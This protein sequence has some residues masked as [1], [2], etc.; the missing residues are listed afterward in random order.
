M[1]RHVLAACVLGAA[2]ATSASA[3]TTVLDVT[4]SVGTSSEAV[5]AAGVQ[6]RALAEPVRGLRLVGEGAWGDRRGP[7]SDVF[8]TAYPYGGRVDI[9]E[10]YAEWL[11]PGTGLRA[12]RAGRYRT[13]FGISSASDHAYL[14]FLRPPLIRYGSYYA[15]STGYL[16]HGVDVLAGAGPVSVEGSVGRPGDVGTTRA[17][18]VEI[19]GRGLVL[20][21]SAIDTMPYLPETFAKGRARYTGLDL[22]WMRRGVQVRGEWLS[23]RPFDGTTTAGGYLD[24]IA[25]T[26]RMDRLTALARVETLDYDTT[27]RFALKTHRVSGGARLRLWQQLAVSAGLAH[28]FGQQ[29]QHERTALDLGLTWAW[30]AD[31]WPRR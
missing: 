7:V 4:Q 6:A 12:L 30:R 31:L 26:R 16:E 8:G 3:Q 17:G 25:H 28:Q 24:L 27:T 21:A 10:A 15:L 20:G 2:M 1:N 13:P 22:R 23:G 5:S 29:T 19:A 11:R 18:R 9:I 14:G